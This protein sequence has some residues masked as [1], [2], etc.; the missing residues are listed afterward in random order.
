MII[1]CHSVRSDIDFEIS[2]FRIESLVEDVLGGGKNYIFRDKHSAASISLLVG[3]QESDG[4]YW[5]MDGFL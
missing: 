4:H 2:I 3:I 5:S 1:L